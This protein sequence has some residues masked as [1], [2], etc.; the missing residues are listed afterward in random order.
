M[1]IPETDS[2]HPECI[3]GG[4]V[5]LGLAVVLVSKCGKEHLEI[6]SSL[7]RCGILWNALLRELFRRE[8]GWVV[9]A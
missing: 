6:G 7:S 9:R 8:K 2:V 1:H 5:K 3:P 4:T